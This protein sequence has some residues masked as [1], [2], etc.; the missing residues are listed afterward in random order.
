M[1]ASSSTIVLP[2]SLLQQAARHADS[3]GVS[4]EQWL[5]ITVA[6]KLRL[7]DETAKFFAVRTA[8]ASGRPLSEILKNVGNNPPDPGDELED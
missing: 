7:E 8:R 1:S 4:T 2:E 3:L 6:E 5:E